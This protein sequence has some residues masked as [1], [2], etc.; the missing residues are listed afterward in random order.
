MRGEQPPRVATWLAE[1]L[2]AGPRRASLLGDLIE[3]YRHG[4]SGVWYWRQVLAAILVGNVHD[5]ASHKTL[6][7]GAL[8]IGWTFYY[9]FS[10]PVTWLG[11][12]AEN[13]VGQQVIVCDPASFWCQFWRNQLSAELMIY[14]AGAVT[15]GI[16]ARLHH[17]H[18]V[19]MLSLYATSVLIFECG[20]V[21]WMVSQT[22]SPVPMSGVALIVANLTVVVRPLSVWVGG[23]W[24]VRSDFG[25]EDAAATP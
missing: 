22:V 13:W 21:G 16:V 6:A 7:L 23:I 12:I 9:L 1:R 11:G 14:V 20:M 18:W 2:V 8:T 19:A 15:G 25:S 4:R 17:T 24:A 5:L 3:Q 10:F